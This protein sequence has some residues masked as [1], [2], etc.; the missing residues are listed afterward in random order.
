MHVVFDAIAVRA[1]SASIVV[2]HELAAWAKGFDTDQ[3]TVLTSAKTQLVIPAGV[4]VE[5]LEPPASGALGELWLRSVGVRRAARRLGA[6]ALISG[7]TASAFLGAHCPRWAIVYDVRHELRPAQFSALRRIVRRVSYRWTFLRAAGLFCISA[8]TRDDIV[9]KRGWLAGKA[10]VTLLGSDH[11]DAWPRPTA[12]SDGPAPEPYALAFGNFGNK[13]ADK[14]LA[15]WVDFCQ[16]D[17]VLTLRLVGMSGAER[18]ALTE[19]AAAL[20]I[21][22][23]VQVMPWLDDAEFQRCFTGSRL[24]IFPSDFEGYGLPAVEAMRLRI[25]VVI[26]TDEALAEVTGGYA[27][28]AADLGPAALA[29]AMRQALAT[30]DAQLD[31]AYRF[32]EPV[33]WSA[34]AEAMRADLI[35][36]IGWRIEPGQADLRQ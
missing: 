11:V 17:S 31:A 23:R 9:A 28:I 16:T 7:V 14:V 24:V 22:D 33:T 10:V 8:R 27:T 15:A 36:R 3:L 6:D 1:G 5:Q 30:T 21:A 20:G 13:N 25:P 18:A 19:Q 26:S 32:I 34:T 35:R 2:E 12:S 4:A 29:A